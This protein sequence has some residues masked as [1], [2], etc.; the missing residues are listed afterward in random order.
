MNE[1]KG[2]QGEGR[3]KG[4]TEQRTEQEARNHKSDDN[5]FP[6]RRKLKNKVTQM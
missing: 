3:E 2:G 5:Y 4:V 1:V 6:A